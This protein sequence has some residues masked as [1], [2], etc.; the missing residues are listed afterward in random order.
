M[1]IPQSDYSVL[2]EASS[3]PCTSSFSFPLCVISKKG[4]ETVALKLTTIAVNETCQRNDTL[5]SLEHALMGAWK[6]IFNS[7]S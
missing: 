4:T 2:L 1:T 3:A 7:I 5:H 6:I